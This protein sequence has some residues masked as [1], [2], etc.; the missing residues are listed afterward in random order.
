MTSSA[1]V[2]VTSSEVPLP[3]TGTPSS[4]RAVA[5]A[6]TG[7]IA[8]RALDRAAAD[9]ERRRYDVVDAEPLEPVHGADDVDDGVERADLVE[10]DLLDRRLVNRRFGLGEPL[11]QVNRALLALGLQRRPADL[12]DDPFQV[13]VR[14]GRSRRR[15][16]R[17]RRFM[18]TELRRGDAG[19]TDA[20]GGHVGV[21]HGEAPERP[22]QRVD[23]Q[24]EIEKR[25]EHHV[26]GGARKAVQIEHRL[27]YAARRPETEVD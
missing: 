23:R 6:G 10:V 8:V 20:L 24:P 7:N 17:S 25:A 18:Q 27:Q 5:G 12:V 26:A 4:S 22:L 16:G 13:V 15:I 9:V 1:P 2:G 14:M 19:A 11:E 3:Y 21:I